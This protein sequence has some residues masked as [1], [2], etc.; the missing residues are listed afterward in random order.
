M[1]VICRQRVP[2]LVIPLHWTVL[3]VPCSCWPD[4]KFC[5][6]AGGWQILQGS[7]FSCLAFSR[8][9]FSETFSTHTAG[10]QVVFL[11]WRGFI[12]T[13]AFSLEIGKKQNDQQEAFFHQLKINCSNQIKKW[14]EFL[15]IYVQDGYGTIGLLAIFILWNFPGE[16]CKANYFTIIIM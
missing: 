6:V 14:I 3:S 13:L 9:I 2:L 11:S 7:R 8:L 10:T 12:N 16:F 4:D 15:L 5:G 1:R